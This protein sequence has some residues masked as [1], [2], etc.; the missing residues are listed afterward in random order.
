MISF[1][2]PVTNGL[3]SHRLVDAVLI[4]VHCTASF[5]VPTGLHYELGS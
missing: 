4:T 2:Y 1:L 5:R 3:E